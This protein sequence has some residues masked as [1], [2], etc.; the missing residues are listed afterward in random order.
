[1]T[2]GNAPTLFNTG[3][4]AFSSLAGP[5]TSCVSGLPAAPTTTGFN[6]GVDLGLPFFF[7]RNISVVTETG[8]VA[9]GASTYYGPLWAF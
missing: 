4:I 6:T 7:G 9:Q 2:I 8:S 1:M 5:S 3:N